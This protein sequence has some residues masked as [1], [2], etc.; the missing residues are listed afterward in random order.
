MQIPL[1]SI[2]GVLPLTNLDNMYNY[3][4]IVITKPWREAVWTS[5]LIH[6]H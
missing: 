5:S 2:C 6:P 3:C 1:R 4:T